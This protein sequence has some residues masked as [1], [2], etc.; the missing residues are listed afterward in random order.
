MYSKYFHERDS[1]RVDPHTHIHD[2]WRSITPLTSV[3]GYLF[4]CCKRRKVVVDEPSNSD[5][6]DDLGERFRRIDVLIEEEEDEER[7]KEAR[8]RELRTAHKMML[9]IEQ[10]NPGSIKAHVARDN[11]RLESERAMNYIGLDA[12]R[13]LLETMRNHIASENFRAL[14]DKRALAAIWNLSAANWSALPD[15]IWHKIYGYL[16]RSPQ[17]AYINRTHRSFY[18]NSVI[19]CVQSKLK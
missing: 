5:S 18:Y 6:D 7:K 13:A 17:T 8:E 9:E 11:A 10:K 19:Y 12:Y 1:P 2:L 15:D 4:G 14:S 3:M 16:T